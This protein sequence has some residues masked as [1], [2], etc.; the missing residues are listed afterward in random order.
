MNA[1]S[2]RIRL[3]FRSDEPLYVQMVGQ[4]EALVKEGVLKPGI[5]FLRC[6]SWQST[7]E[8]TSAQW[9]GYIAFSMNAGSF[10]PN[11]DAEP[12][13]GIVRNEMVYQ[14]PPMRKV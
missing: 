2:G 6:A 7:C 12:T 5:S 14:N 10:P 11:A 9:R 8:S 13:S 1:L 4:I 3:D